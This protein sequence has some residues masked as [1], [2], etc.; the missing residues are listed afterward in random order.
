MA[1]PHATPGQLID[2]QPLGSRLQGEK[3]T[4]LF[5]S[6][7]LEVIRLV[8]QAGKSFPPHSVAGEITVHCIEGQIDVT[9]HGQSHVLCAGQMLFLSGGVEHGVV[10]IQD[11]SA[12]VTI[13]LVP[14]QP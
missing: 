1:I 14:G 5:K 11:S 8:L 9:A 2:V 12:L 4:A 3:T 7:H 10:A 6:E 13:A